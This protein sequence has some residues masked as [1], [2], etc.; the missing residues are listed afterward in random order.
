M[1]PRTLIIKLLMAEE[2]GHRANELLTQ[3]LERVDFSLRDR[4]F[5]SALFY[6]CLRWQLRLDRDLATV[7]DTDLNLLNPEIRNILRLG[8]Y[9][10]DHAYSVPAEVGVMTSVDL[11]REFGMASATGLVNAV[12]RKL[13][14]SR[15]RLLRKEESLAFS[16]SSEVYG[17]LKKGYGESVARAIAEASLVERSHIAIRPNR[18]KCTTDELRLLLQSEA[19][20]V[21]P[22][23][24]LSNALRINLAGRDLSKLDSF[25]R[26]YW[27]VQDEAAQLLAELIRPEAGETVYDACAAPGGKTGSLY[28]LSAGNA[29]VLAAD[30]KESRLAKVSKLIK[31]MGYKPSETFG[32]AGIELRVHDASRLLPGNLKFSQ[33]VVDMPCSASGL[34]AK[35]ADLA[36]NLSYRKVQELIPIQRS[37]LQ[38]AASQVEIGGFLTYSTCSILPAENSEQIESFL[39][40]E[41]GNNYERVDITGLLPDKIREANTMSNK[42]EVLLRPDLLPEIDGFFIARLR[43]VR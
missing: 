7:L 27:T 38:T 17:M 18:L 6:G 43:R 9:Q 10:I 21:L 8:L 22:G 1:K 36:K 24:Y 39:A 20:E 35:Q 30:L 41:L 5:V 37:I 34:L 25:R 31:R 19:V 32:K 13:S 16:L 40:T 26:G 11:C 42:G 28:E 14:K 33:V 15:L 4:R 2:R 12:L 3:E 23:C 29:Y